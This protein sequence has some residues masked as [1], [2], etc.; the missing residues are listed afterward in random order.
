MRIFVNELSMSN[1]FNSSTDFINHLIFLMKLRKQNENF[2]DRFVCPRGISEK[3]VCNGKTLRQT[4]LDYNSRD[5]TNKVLDWLD[6]AGPFLEHDDEDYGKILCEFNG[7]L[8]EDCVIENVASKIYRNEEAKTYSFDKGNPDFSYTPLVINYTDNVSSDV[9][10]I[11]NIWSEDQIS[12]IANTWVRRPGSWPELIDY[13]KNTFKNLIFHDDII[14]C[15]SRHPFSVVISDR[16]IALMDILNKYVESHDESKR[17]TCI[18][19]ELIRNFFSGDKAPFTDESSTNINDF[20]KEMT[21]NINGEPELC[22]W[23]GKIKHQEFRIHFQYPFSAKT[24]KLVVVY[25]GPK[26]TKK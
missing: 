15:I 17:R 12:T 7:E 16:V 19:N 25:I 9:L 5:F 3:I 22:S 10:Y 13:L 24:D 4:V 23:H 8:I 14:G 2:G 1:Q 26:I 11:D 18:T 20:R 6:K 21:F